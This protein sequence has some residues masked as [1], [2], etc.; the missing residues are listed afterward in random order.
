MYAIR[1]YYELTVANAFGCDS[2]VRDSVEVF[3]YIDAAFNV[4]RADSCSP[5]RLDIENLSSI[6][7]RF[8]DWE[9][10]EGSVLRQS[11]PNDSTPNFGT[12]TNTTLETDT[13]TLRLMA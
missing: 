10:S 6:G 2:T 9:L 1:S 4:P 7:A 8:W 11:I 12:L 5:F 13:L 3:A